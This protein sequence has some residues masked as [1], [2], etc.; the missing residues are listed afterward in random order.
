[1]SYVV[2][3]LDEDMEVARLVDM[4][5]RL[6]RPRML[7]NGGSGFDSSFPGDGEDLPMVKDAAKSAVKPVPK[8]ATPAKK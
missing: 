8:P 5:S 2:R 3:Q 6:Y 4:K 1:M 7:P